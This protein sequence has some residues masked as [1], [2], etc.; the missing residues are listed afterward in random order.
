MIRTGDSQVSLTGAT[1]STVSIHDVTSSKA[2]LTTWKRAWPGHRRAGKRHR[3]LLV[4]ASLLLVAGCVGAWLLWRGDDPAS[5]APTT[6]TVA[7]ETVKET[8]AASGTLAAASTE[9]LGFEVNGTVTEV[10]VDEGDRV[11]AGDAIAKVDDSSL[12]AA[13]AAAASALEAAEV[14]LD[15]DIDNGVDDV[16][17]AAAEAAVVAA[18]ASLEQ[19]KDDVDGAVLRSDTRG[20]VTSVGIEVG[21]VVGGGSAAAG[22]PE[23]GTAAGTGTTSDAASDSGTVTVTSS[24]RFVVEATVS[25]DDRDRLEEGQQAELTVSGVDDTV[26]GTVDSIGLVA[27]T[28]STGGAVFPVTIEVTGKQENLYAGTSA[29]ASIIVK[30]TEGVLTVSSRALSTEDDKTYVEKVVDG[31]T[32]RT[33]VEIGATYGMSTEVL[34]GLEEGDVVEL[35]AV[36]SPRG[37]GGGGDDRPRG[38]FPGGGRIPEG[39]FPG[40]GAPGGGRP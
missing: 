33:E 34:S 14:T 35:P 19:A 21:D 39:G 30:Q 26:Y 32:V 7:T 38:G 9:D 20:T 18:E 4:L 10:R 16:Q 15:E 40:G 23:T 31:A 3:L 17:I 2:L 28:S 12:K 37:G 5:A 22:S 1:G 25:S 36:E 8:V 29:D 27:E 6:A 13:R 24:R 11:R